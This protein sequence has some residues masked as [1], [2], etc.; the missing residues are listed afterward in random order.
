[1]AAAFGNGT[2][3]F[4][5]MASAPSGWTRDTT[6]VSDHAIVITGIGSL[7]GTAGGT[8]NFTTV[9]IGTAYTASASSSTFSNPTSPATIDIPTHTHSGTVS[10]RDSLSF[11]TTETGFTWPYPVRTPTTPRRPTYY[12][13]ISAHNSPK[14]D[15]SDWSN[16]QPNTTVS[17]GNLIPGNKYTIASFGNT[18][19]ANWDILTGNIN[20]ST[21]PQNR[22]LYNRL[23]GHE[24]TAQN[25]GTG[26]GTGTARLVSSDDTHFHAT[27]VTAPFTSSGPKTFNLGVKYVDLILA[28][29]N[30]AY[31]ATWASQTATTIA[32]GGTVS[33]TWNTPASVPTG[34]TLYWTI[35][36][37]GMTGA[38][39][40]STLSGSFTST[41][42]T[43][44]QPTIT[45]PDN[46]FWDNGGSFIVQLR[47][48]SVDGTIMAASQKIAIT[49]PN[50][51]AIFTVIPAGGPAIVNEDALGTF[52]FSSTRLRVGEILTYTIN[53]YT[54]TTITTA[55][56]AADFSNNLLTGK[57]SITSSASTSLTVNPIID[58]LVEGVP[59][60]E[61]FTVSLSTSTGLVLVTSSSVYIGDVPPTA[62]FTVIP[63]TISVNTAGTF[64]IT[65]TNV[66][67]GTILTWEISGG[68]NYQGTYTNTTGT[69]YI[70]N[71]TGTF[72][73]TP[74]SVRDI[75]KAYSVSNWTFGAII[76]N[77]TG[78]T[79]QTSAL[80]TVNNS[81]VAFVTPTTTFDQG[82][83]VRYDINTTN[84]P[85]STQL[86]WK[87]AHN[88]GNDAC[89]SAVQGYVTIDNNTG[90]FVISAT[91]NNTFAGL[92]WTTHT[93][94]IFDFAG[95][96]K[97][98][99]SGF[100]VTPVTY[101]VSITVYQNY[102][103]DTYSF[104]TPPISISEGVAITLQ[105]IS[106]VNSGTL[107][108]TINT[109]PTTAADFTGS[110]VSGSITLNGTTVID[111]TSLFQRYQQSF[112]ITTA[113]LDMIAESTETFTVSLR[114]L[115][116]V[117]ATSNI[118]SIIDS[119][120]SLYYFINPAT[121]INEG[122][123]T[124]YTV[125]AVNTAITTL[126]WDIVNNT[127]APGNFT[128]AVSGTI[129]LTAG[130]GTFSFTTVGNGVTGGDKSFTLNLRTAI[131]PG[132]IV[133]SVSPIVLVDTSKNPAYTFPLLPSSISEDITPT[134][135]F[136]TT[137]VNPGTYN[138][139]IN[140]VTSAFADFMAPLLYN[141]SVSFNGTSQY[142][143]IPTN[144]SLSFGTGDFTVEFFVRPTAYKTAGNYIFSA[145]GSPSPEAYAFYIRSNGCFFWQIYDNSASSETSMPISLN[146]WTHIA[147]CRIAGTVTT[148]IN[149]ILKDTISGT[150]SANGYGNRQIG[151]DGINAKYFSGLIS[152][153]RIIKG[154]GLYT[155]D[156]IV[157]TTQLYNIT[158][159]SLLACQGPTVTTDNST[160][161]AGGPWTIT[162]SV[163]APTLSSTVISFVG[164]GGGAATGTFSTSGSFAIS[165]GSFTLPP[166]ADR[167]TEGYE[168]FNI[169]VRTGSTL[170]AGTIVATSNQISITDTSTDPTY[171]F[172]NPT[173]SLT[174]GVS[175]SYTVNITNV[176]IGSTL[177]WTI[178]HITTSL[179]D[180]AVSSGSFLNSTG[181][182][183]SSFGTF[184][185]TTIT[186]ALTEGD[187]IFSLQI[188]I[189]S[190]TGPV[191]LISPTITIVD[192][193]FN[194]TY[195]FVTPATSINEG[196]VTTYTLNT[197]DVPIGTRLY[198][199]IENITTSTTDFNS[200]VAS[201]VYFP[202]TGYLTAPNNATFS[203]GTSDFTIECW[204][205]PPTTNT[206]VIFDTRSP[207]TADKGFDFIF[208]GGF[209]KFGTAG[210]FYIS[211]TT[212]FSINTWYHVALSRS[213]NVFTLF[214]D[215]KSQGSTTRALDL[216]NTATRIGFGA[217]GYT[218]GYIS[219]LRVIKGT[220][221]YSNNFNPV[222]PLYNIAQT[223]LL[224]CQGPT[225]TTDN[226]TANG[227]LP[228][229]ITTVGT[230]PTV[231]TTATPPFIPGLSGSFTVNNGTTS[232]GSSSFTIDVRNEAIPE[233]NE[234]FTLNVRKDN[235]TGAVVA[236]IPVITLVDPTYPTYAFGVI[237]ASIN[238]G[239]AGTFNVTTTNVSNAT[240]LYWT[241]ATNSGDF[242]T[243]NGSFT[244]TNNTGSFSVTPTADITTEG[245]ETFIV[246]IS[247]DSQFV[248]VV[249]TSSSVTINDTSTSPPTYAFGVIPTSINEGVAGTFNVTTTNVANSTI[250]YW[251]IAT[252]SGDFST[253]NGSFTITSNTG[254]F[255]VTPTADITTEGNE[256]FIVKISTDS[257][258]VNVVATSS[259][260][261]INDTSID[262]T[263]T[264]GVIPTSIN[265]GSPGTFNVI[266]TNIA[267]STILYWTIATNSGDF[268]TVNGSFTITNNTG[269]FSVTP[270]A[271][272][273]TE[274]SETFTVS[275]R[276]VSVTGDVVATSS[277]VTIND[278]SIDPTYT[279]GVIPTSINE[280]SSGTFN[281]TT[282]NVS[283]G[284]TLYW[285]IATNSSDF[286]TTNGSFT[287]T[288]NTGSFSVTPTA[289]LTTEGAE[290]F[291]VSIRKVSVTGDVVATSS[292]VTIN[293]TSIDPPTYTFGVIPTSINEGSSGTFNVTTTNVA[294]STI[295]YWFVY[296]NA[297]DFSTINGSFT[298]TNN[299]GSFSVTPTADLTT[300]G[301]ETFIVKISTDSQFV[302]VVATSSPVIINDTSTSPPTYAFGVIP[303]SINE[304]SS[305]TF[306]VTTTNVANS[307]TLYWFVYTNAG[308]FSTVNGS[309]T[310]TSNT[311]SFTVTP[312][313]D[314]TTEGSETFIVKISTDSQF[315]NV[316]AT[317]STVTINDTSIT[318]APTYAFGVIPTSINEDSPG[319]F[320]VTTTN[321]ANATTLYWTIATNEGDFS[322]I[323]GSFTITSNTGSFT[324]TP[325]ADLT[326]EGSETFTVSIRTVSVTGDVVATSSPVTIND[327]STATPISSGLE[328][329]LDL[330][331][332]SSYLG[333]GPTWYDLSGNGR[334]V[335]FNTFGAPTYI[336]D[337]D[338]SYFNFVSTEKKR[339]AYSAYQIPIQTASTAFTWSIWVYPVTNSDSLLIGYRGT[340]TSKFYK[341][342]TKKFEMGSA[343][344]F[345][346]FTLNV[347]QNI[348]A[349]YD[350]SQS[351][352]ANMKL[353][354]NGTQV[355]LRDADQPT[356]ST[357]TMFFYIGGDAVAN[358]FADARIN[359]L[360]VYHRA[361]SAEE[362]TTNFN[363]FKK[364]F[365]L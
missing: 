27:S 251:T 32:K 39:S 206:S 138:W 229:T 49:E 315:V 19:D 290:T 183:A 328:L 8:T 300:E 123:T 102:P 333:S 176:P 101:G 163:S 65:T 86:V 210:S 53:P 361:L 304:G 88:I 73:I 164:A 364:R 43:T 69:F 268:S 113:A 119:P 188:R 363:R 199:T 148:Y 260:V 330:G 334:D 111:S 298:I 100:G 248:N 297:G 272:I 283:N 341:L 338:K 259:P 258:F 255:T 263:Y 130:V 318:P 61:A 178:N 170:G 81:T 198:Y 279:F 104:I 340:T 351:G 310:I 52:T 116:G 348:V 2:K 134:I 154:K 189:N 174:E 289:D 79:L 115:S 94:D 12:A 126:Y 172:V 286:G 196:T 326:T 284:T 254:S 250:L 277:P 54:N 26:Y 136:Q 191:V 219:N 224:I 11:G 165:T 24:F 4:F 105:F 215:G 270:T 353:Y 295:L 253:V 322:T 7:G 301:S 275:I 47:S 56:S 207:D 247:T 305:G 107:Y 234:T 141:N 133:A 223:V 245:N 135:N 294:N 30:G 18:T 58:L 157:P 103:T 264:F 120:L 302:N 347:W 57:V 262:P 257:Q 303:T 276:K 147:V 62:T 87:I 25:S 232:S 96:F 50:P 137:S 230:A 20:S 77:S 280:G 288:N 118:I 66:P 108:W 355:G 29:K 142:L 110:V 306:N 231:V 161:N 213:G 127:T 177:H 158:G 63:T 228:W 10:V 125:N 323:N 221:L 93:I 51:T 202:G 324:V 55:S 99:G 265:E 5:A 22:Y 139:T 117:V 145:W 67:N 185:I 336:S 217:N 131:A 311:G 239:V 314:L 278:T 292:T 187:E 246:K 332:L 331:K 114:T 92:A 211:G 362:V 293:D 153:V 233:R 9:H 31:G 349:V 343:E 220:G 152:N 84:I 156:F 358:E 242:S 329:N 287:I 345:Y 129:I 146:V 91:R 244:I 200:V 350:G 238:E 203:L 235:V 312:T 273:T 34:S 299:T 13:Y 106:N 76:K 243:V 320:N 240:T 282:T 208:S 325:T 197:T 150:N 124:T 40:S 132:T 171:T 45:I 261:T 226:S 155:S 216:T 249:A 339:F 23:L 180:F 327:S 46:G 212:P 122:T 346:M 184:T 128:G 271:D 309:F 17:M 80:V 6:T 291:T 44:V 48:D 205:Y 140:N 15:Q 354:V 169:I 352:T 317:S 98:T 201:S 209:L 160:A 162:T 89:F 37:T 166:I 316:V 335:T 41:V 70:Y 204:I 266:T 194:P 83:T 60:Y 71:N 192:T 218:N 14:Y 35:V 182:A 78:Q 75:F 256:T 112:T 21:D 360:A 64:T 269:S 222:G 159:T 72:Y 252:N 28:I 42:T 109:T 16:A 95:T 144:T 313:A 121:Y 365:G 97:L 82:Q 59:T 149:G 33:I 359:Q 74:N 267:N 227:G 344:I 357:S 214:L 319:T 241:I 143:T 307:T 225:V 281:V 181:T 3:K 1:M 168:F 321:V 356:L 36:N 179:D 342:T 85:N 237:P 190:I 173:T 175:I 308:D 337:G 193:S 274:G 236:S 285:T 186:D 151:A 38:L 195:T 296:T 167:L 68:A 90:S